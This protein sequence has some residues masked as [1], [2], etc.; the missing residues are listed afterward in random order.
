MGPPL[1]GFIFI[2]LKSR[3]NL[4]CRVSFHDNNKKDGDTLCL[5][6][7]MVNNLT[8]KLNYGQHC[9]RHISCQHEMGFKIPFQ[10]PFPGK[11]ANG[12]AKKVR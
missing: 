5:L 11:T 4:V 3:E 9:H 2:A 12:R 8:G 7:Y 1:V 6:F 10:E